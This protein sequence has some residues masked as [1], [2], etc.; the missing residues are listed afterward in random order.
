[1]LIPRRSITKEEPVTVEEI[2][3]FA[4]AVEIGAVIPTIITKWSYAKSSTHPESYQVPAKVE[5]LKKF[6]RLVKTDKGVFPWKD[7]LI[8]Y[9]CYHGPAIIETE[10]KTKNKKAA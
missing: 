10:K 2:N 4:E 5:V 3:K 7:I 6:P 9:Y 8:G 1:M